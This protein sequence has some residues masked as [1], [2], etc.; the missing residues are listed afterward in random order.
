M[1]IALKYLEVFNFIKKIDQ[2]KMSKSSS[3][4]TFNFKKLSNENNYKLQADRMYAILVSKG[5]DSYIK[6][7]KVDPYSRVNTY[8][9][10]LKY[11]K[12]AA[13]IQLVLKDRPLA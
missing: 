4:S 5:L 8:Q 13:L 9:L 6:R 12:A 1:S 11:K 2:L 7:P 10:I 3:I